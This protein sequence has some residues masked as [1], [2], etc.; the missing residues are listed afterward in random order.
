ML[1]LYELALSPFAQKVK[2]GLREKG[3]DF[4]TRNGFDPVYKADFEQGN[5]RREVPLLIDG[6]T[7]IS[8]STIILDY[9]DERWPC[10]PLMPENPA[11][12]AEVRLLEEIADTRLEALNYCIA[13]VIS[14]PVGADKAVEQVVLNSKAE[15]ACKCAAKEFLPH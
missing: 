1:T 7:R 9:A 3:I 13:E 14:F 10:R 12:R 5:P 8:D 6:D 11:D 15:I 4:E 2:I